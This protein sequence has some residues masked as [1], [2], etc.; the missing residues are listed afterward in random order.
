MDWTLGM[1]RTGEWIGAVGEWWLLVPRGLSEPARAQ[2][3]LTLTHSVVPVQS[4]S[5][6]PGSPKSGHHILLPS[7]RL[8]S[9]EP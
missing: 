8:A 4:Q 5:S 7:L 2:S 9:L 3:S 1:M 6:K